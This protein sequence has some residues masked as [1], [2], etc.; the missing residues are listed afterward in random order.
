MNRAGLPVYGGEFRGFADRAGATVPIA[1]TAR[2]K[3][4]SGTISCLEHTQR[5]CPQREEE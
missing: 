1:L 3:L 5:R 4:H 2:C